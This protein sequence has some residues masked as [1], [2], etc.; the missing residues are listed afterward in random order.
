M[1]WGFT[2][3]A[4]AMIPGVGAVLVWAPIAVYLGLT[5]HWG[6]TALLALWGGVIVSTIDNILYPMLVGSQL[7]AHTVT[8]LI[9]ILGGVALFGI[10][11]VILGPVA[12]TAAAALLE[13]WHTRDPRPEL[14]NQRSIP[15]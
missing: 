11:G 9:S 15:S 10:T 3:A 5:G 7:R 2:T 8:I 12:F 13:F 6:K 1:L 4:F 14:P